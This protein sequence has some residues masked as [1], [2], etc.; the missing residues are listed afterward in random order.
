MV[1]D[2]G[3]RRQLKALDNSF[4]VVWD[5]GGEKWEIWS[6]PADGKLPYHVTT[7][8]TKNRTYRELGA[9][10]LVSLQQS[11][12]LGYD[13]II[14]YLDEHNNQIQRRK[15]QDFLDKIQ[16]AV[17]D[18]FATIHSVR[19]R[20]I[21]KLYGAEFLNRIPILEKKELPI[22]KVPLGQR[23]IGATTDA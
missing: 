5:W 13:N 10:I 3:F 19:G 4:E 8:Q 6:F 14:K 21:E 20:P 15:R 1:P 23:I 11:M 12:S 17:R 22:I 16:W 7:V 9:D 2:K 18:N